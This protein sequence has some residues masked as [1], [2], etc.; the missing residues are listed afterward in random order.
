M[1]PH[2]GFNNASGASYT[3]ANNAETLVAVGPVKELL[4]FGME[5]ELTIIVP[6]YNAGKVLPACLESL[7]AQTRPI[8]ILIADDGSTDDTGAIADSAAKRSASV[9]VLHLIHAGLIATRKASLAAVET[10]YFAFVDA[11]DRIE[12]TF[13]EEMLDAALRHEA[14]LVFCPYTCVYDGVARHV[15]YSG[16]GTVFPGITRPIRNNPRLLM[17]VPTFFWG[18]L[19]RTDYV[20]PRIAYAPEECIPLEDIPAIVPLLIDI[21]SLAMV[22]TPLY[23]YT[24]SSESMCR[25]SKQELSRLTAMRTLHERLEAIGALPEFLP[26]LH[27]INRCHLFDQLEKMRGYCD[28][29]H[30]HHVVHEYFRHLDGTLPHWRPHPFHPTF[31]A[32]YWHWIIAQNSLRNKFRHPGKGR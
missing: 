30:Q 10:A 15:S 5:A 7:Y 6:A 11:D 32:A 2:A 28:P 18:K 22:T 24:I 1:V 16:D 4:I 9:R 12:R 21:P 27:A 31:Y 23:R 20:R 19:F 8:C 25:V 26:Q 17:R 13:A 3:P 14:D 29:G